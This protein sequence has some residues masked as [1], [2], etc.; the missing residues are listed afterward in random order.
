LVRGGLII[1]EITPFPGL[2][3]IGPGERV[4]DILGWGLSLV[5]ILLSALA[6][7]SGGGLIGT[8]GQSS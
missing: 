2:D 6:Q 5:I 3:K 8:G 7:I 4:E 1:P